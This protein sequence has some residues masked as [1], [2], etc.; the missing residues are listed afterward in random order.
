MGAEDCFPDGET[1]EGMVLVCAW[2]VEL[3]LDWCFINHE[4]KDSFQAVEGG[5]VDWGGFADNNERQGGVAIAN[6]GIG[7]A[8]ELYVCGEHDGLVCVVANGQGA[9]GGGNLGCCCLMRRF[10]CGWRD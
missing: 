8:V 3:N 1:L 2:Q 4:V 5:F 10:M 7:V 6:G 9:G